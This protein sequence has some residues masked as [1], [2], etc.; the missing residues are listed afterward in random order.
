MKLGCLDQVDERLKTSARR[1]PRS[2]VAGQLLPGVRKK[3]HIQN[4]SRSP[5]VLTPEVSVGAR[6]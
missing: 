5:N 1:F 4:T 3:Q 2:L 6:R